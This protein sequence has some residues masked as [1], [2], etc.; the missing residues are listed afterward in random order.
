MPPMIKAFGNFP[1][2]LKPS[3]ERMLCLHLPF[4]V[5]TIKFEGVSNDYHRVAHLE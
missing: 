2:D 4:M 3:T 1:L 5:K